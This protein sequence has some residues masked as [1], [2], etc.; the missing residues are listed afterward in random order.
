MALALYFPLILHSRIHILRTSLFQEASGLELKIHNDD[1][2][3]N[4]M[5]RGHRR[6][7]VYHVG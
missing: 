7:K 6:N 1:V 4:K 3:S 2:V 5:C